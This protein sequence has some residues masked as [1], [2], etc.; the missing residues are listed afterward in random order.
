MT[1]YRTVKKNHSLLSVSFQTI[2]DY[3]HLLKAAAEALQPL[4][5]RALLYLAAAVSDFYIPRDQMVS[6]LLF[7]NFSAP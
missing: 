6:I 5:N 7:F 2:A 1:K 3:L 4:E